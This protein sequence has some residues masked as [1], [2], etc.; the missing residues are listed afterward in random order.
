ML[1]PIAT[2]S[3]PLSMT[4]GLPYNAP[5]LDAMRFYQNVNQYIQVSI[6]IPY[7]VPVNY[8]ICLQLTSAT[9]Y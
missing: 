5:F 4:L 9:L 1:Y 2:V 6:L 8:A 3:Y 7:S